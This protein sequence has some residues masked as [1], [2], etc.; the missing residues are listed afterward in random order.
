MLKTEKNEE[1]GRELGED[2]RERCDM[3]PNNIY[4]IKVDLFE[5]TVVN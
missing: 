2:N 3:S 5:F 1:L 4:L